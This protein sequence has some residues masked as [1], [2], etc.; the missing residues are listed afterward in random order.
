MKLHQELWQSFAQSHN[1][2]DHQLQQFQQYYQHLIAATEQFNLTT[3]T[4]LDKVLTDH[5][6]DSLA[7]DQ[8]IDISTIGMLA[9]IGTGAGFPSIPLKI[10]YPKLPMVLIEVN[11]KKLQFLQ[12]IIDILKLATIELCDLDWRTFLRKSSFPITLFCARASL[13]PQELIRLFQPASSYKDA[14]LVY[15]A[16]AQWQPKEK[17]SFLR[18]ECPY[19]VGNKKRKLI[20]FGRHFQ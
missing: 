6:S 2:T 1:L 15:W 9:D 16:S 10:K 12:E 20:F 8:C 5:F 7:L 11:H 3:I 4:E 14:Q 17:L 13:Q 18:S 19:K